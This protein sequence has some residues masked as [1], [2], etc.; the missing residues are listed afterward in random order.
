MAESSACTVALELLERMST[1]SAGQSSGNPFELFAPEF[2][3]TAAGDTPASGTYTSI[4]E[5]QRELMASL[6]RLAISPG[7]GLFVTCVIEEGD[8]VV[9][10]ARSRGASR[11]GMPY[12]N[13][14][15]FLFGVA[16]GRIVRMLELLDTSLF[17]CAAL[18]MHLEP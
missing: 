12:N 5:I 16:D 2:S 14:L 9:V 10:R 6:E 1:A 18:D 7:Y 4:E 3:Y 11:D 17:M 15:F 13:D 8:R